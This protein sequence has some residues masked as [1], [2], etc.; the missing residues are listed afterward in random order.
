[1]EIRVDVT[2]ATQFAARMRG[3]EPIVRAE[4]TTAMQR[5]VLAVEGGAK[6]YVRQDTHTL[7][8]SITSAVTPITGGVQG[9]V[10]SNQPHAAPNEF[11]R[12]AGRAMPPPGVILEWMRRR[13]IDPRLEFVI[14]RAIGRRGIPA[15]PYLRRALTELAPQI[16]AEFRAVPGRVMARLGL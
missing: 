12:A 2:P 5:S 8:R 7:Q 11:G 1:M 9:V 15:Q 13:G 16:A 3:A 4:M 10:G 6:R 14:R